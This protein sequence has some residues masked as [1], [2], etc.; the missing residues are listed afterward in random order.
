MFTYRDSPSGDTVIRAEVSGERG[1]ASGHVNDLSL[2]GAA[3]QFSVEQTTPFDS[4]ERVTL[5]FHFPQER[6]VQVEAIV[7]TQTEM[8]GFWQF[9]FVFI[10]PSTIRAKLPGGLLRSFNERAAFRVEPSVT[11]PVKLQIASLGF[12]ASGHMRDISF[13]GLG[14][15]IDAGTGNRLTPGLEACVE[16]T[17]PGQD[18]LLTCEAVIRNRRAL[19]KGALLIGL[20][21]DWRGSSDTASRRRHVT[22]YVMTRQ[23]EL[24]RARV[25]R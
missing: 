19:S 23:R 12:H 5:V 2:Y 18:R 7:R 15:V 16:F 4:S 10:A 17:L 6:S 13:D 1:Q 22:D 21:L 14:A 8:D 11:V 3:I 9:G 24:L 20:R 25:E